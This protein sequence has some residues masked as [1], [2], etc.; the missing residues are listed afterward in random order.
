[1]V[2]VAVVVATAVGAVTGSDRPGVDVVDQPSPPTGRPVFST[3]TGVT[4]L[5]DDGYDG[6]TALDLDTGIVGRRIVDGQRAGDQ[7]YRLFRS[8]DSL[9][10]GWGEVFA[11][12]LD[13]GPSVSLGEATLA[14]PAS[15]PG[16]VWLASWTG[17]RVGEGGCTDA[18]RRLAR[19][20]RE[21][22][23]DALRPRG[24][25]TASPRRGS[26]ASAIKGHGGGRRSRRRGGQL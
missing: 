1:M 22:R 7:P 19:H 2:T 12:P 23:V 20:C 13:G 8:D 6:V 17:G 14:V 5:L 16:R 4:L 15:E 21:D 10:V 11:A 25:A 9:I 3:P 18:S 24:H 26:A